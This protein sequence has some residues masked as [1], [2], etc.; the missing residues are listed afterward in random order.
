MNSLSLRSWQYRGVASSEIGGPVFE[1]V[2]VEDWEDPKSIA[3]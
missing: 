1:V 3:G 2:R